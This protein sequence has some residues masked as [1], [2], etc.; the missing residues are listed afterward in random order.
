MN[1]SIGDRDIMAGASKATSAPD[2]SR[3]PCARPHRTVRPRL[4][5]TLGRPSSKQASGQTRLAVPTLAMADNKRQGAERI[6]GSQRSMHDA[7]EEVSGRI[8]T[9]LQGGVVVNS[10]LQGDRGVD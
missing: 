4:V 7:L 1:E 8:R 5:S 9:A 3:A 6:P 2:P 10:L